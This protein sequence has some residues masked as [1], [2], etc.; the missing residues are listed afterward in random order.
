MFKKNLFLF[1]IFLLNECNNI[2]YKNSKVPLYNKLDITNFG[3]INDTN[4]L[5][6]AYLKFDT[7]TSQ[8]ICYNEIL[9]NFGL[10]NLFFYKNANYLFRLFVDNDIAYGEKSKAFIFNFE[11]KGNSIYS[12]LFI[13]GKS[14]QSHINSG[15]F[16]DSIF[17]SK[18]FNSSN[19]SLG[20]S[21]YKVTPIY[22]SIIS[23]KTI[24]FKVDS[25][26]IFLNLLDNFMNS[27]AKKIYEFSRIFIE[28]NINGNY[29][30]FNTSTLEENYK[31]L[32]VICNF[33][34]KINGLKPNDINI[35]LWG[36]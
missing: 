6:K 35:Y 16:N 15:K 1:L 24:I 14:I 8:L 13:L 21:L 17:K 4:F 31:E 34:K 10:T 27:K 23:K 3:L 2:K 33:L 18:D 29:K 32:I 28:L 7:D 11:K 5:K 30:I 22:D 36:F 26:N 19:F 25:L 12:D 20:N 9:T